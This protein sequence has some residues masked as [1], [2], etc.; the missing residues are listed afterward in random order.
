[1]EETDVIRTTVAST[2]SRR[3]RVALHVAHTVTG[4]YLAIGILGALRTHLDHTATLAVFTASPA[5]SLAWLAIGLVG[6]G[7]VTG[8]GRA[9]RYL[10]GAGVLL[11]AWALACLALDGAG[12]DMFLRDAQTVA[13]LLISGLGSLAASLGT[14][15]TTPPMTPSDDAPPST[16]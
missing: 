4:L 16:P 10:L 7:M 6:G 14:R 13:L 2:L 5:S 12:A 8:P 3:D 1:M 15:G 11:V 9:R